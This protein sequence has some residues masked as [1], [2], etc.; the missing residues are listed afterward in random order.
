MLLND[1]AHLYL[2][3]KTSFLPK[4]TTPNIDMPIETI[5]LEKFSINCSSLRTETNGQDKYEGQQGG[6]THV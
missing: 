1:Q 3:D 5:Q 2:R 6:H 4:K